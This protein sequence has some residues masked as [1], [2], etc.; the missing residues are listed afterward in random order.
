MK[1]NK[2]S[3]KYQFYKD[4]ASYVLDFGEV[5]RAEDK[6]ATVEITEVEEAGLLQ[7]QGTCGCVVA[8]KTLHDKDRASFK[9][10]Y[11]DCDLGFNKVIL[12]QYN[13]QQLTTILLTGK[14]N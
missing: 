5:K 4:G 1:V 12:V 2:T 14:C 11:T 9:I 6:S 7:L 8:E 10:T 13:K 3:E